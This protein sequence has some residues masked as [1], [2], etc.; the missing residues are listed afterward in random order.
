MNPDISATANLLQCC[1]KSLTLI[2]LSLNYL[3]KEKTKC[4]KRSGWPTTKKTGLMYKVTININFYY[5]LLIYILLR[6][7]VCL[8]EV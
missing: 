8:S 3:K 2:K 6:V 5:F 7:H 1:C 4:V